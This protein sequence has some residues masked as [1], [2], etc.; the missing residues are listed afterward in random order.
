MADLY[1]KVM[2]RALGLPTNVRY[3]DHKTPQTIQHAAF[4]EVSQA[5]FVNQSQWTV[6]HV[7]QAMIQ[8][9]PTATHTLLPD[10]LN[11]G[12]H[13]VIPLLAF[14]RQTQPAGKVLVSDIV[15]TLTRRTDSTTITVKRDYTYTFNATQ[16]KAGLA[17]IIQRTTPEQLLHMN[18]RQ[19][20]AET[21]Q[22]HIQQQAADKQT[23]TKHQPHAT[24]G[25]EDNTQQFIRARA[26]QQDKGSKQSEVPA[27]ATAITTIQGHFEQTNTAL[28]SA[29][30]IS[31]GFSGI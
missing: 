3:V 7:R 4:R 26:L 21:I 16:L 22:Q 31:G 8:H 17:G 27:S 23:Q 10:T 9:A 11:T 24:A 1:S 14:I 25:Y 6:Q 13:P 2:S 30:H 18:V 12:A 28:P 20:L 29:S 5:A 19:L 15:Q